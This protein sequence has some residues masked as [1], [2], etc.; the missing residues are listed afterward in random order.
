LN[1]Y[2]ERKCGGGGGGGVMAYT[3]LKKKKKEIWKW[4]QNELHETNPNIPDQNQVEESASNLPLKL[5]LVKF[6][7][8]Q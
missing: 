3:D 6:K 7:T 4:K 1:I 2:K 8:L 5:C